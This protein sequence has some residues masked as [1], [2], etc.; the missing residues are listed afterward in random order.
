MKNT[1]TTIIII[2]LIIVGGV[3]YFR[4]SQKSSSDFEVT[5]ENIE[6]VHQESVSEIEEK[7][8]EEEV[9]VESNVK[10]FTMIA[11]QF[12]FEPDTITVNEGDTVK[13]TISSVDVAHGIE[14]PDFGVS[15]RFGE[16]ESVEV[17]F[18]ADKKGSFSFFCNVYCGSGHGAMRG[19]LI[20]K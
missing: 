13:I 1:I 16:G 11:K 15:K 6:R 3:L 7:P 2:L 17:E 10:E 20:V 14:I 12:A 5:T 19:T 4:Q 18:V 8:A 9:Q